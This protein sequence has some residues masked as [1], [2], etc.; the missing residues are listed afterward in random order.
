MSNFLKNDSGGIMIYSA[1]FL[2]IGVGAGALAID[3]GRMELL[4]SEMQHSADAAALSGA[5]QLNGHDDAMT[6]G[7]NVARNAMSQTSNVP[8]TGGNTPLTVATVNFYSSYAT[9]TIATTGLEAKFVEV[10]LAPQ[11]VNYMFAPVYSAMFGAARSATL[12]A[13]AV[14]RVRPFVCHAPPLMMCDLTELDPA[15]D[16]TDPANI[17]RQVRLKEPQGGSG[18][19][20]PGNFGLLALP[21]GSSGAPDIEGALAAIEPSECYEIDVITATGSKTNKVKD[22]INTRFDVGNMPDP[23]APNVI[24]YPQ[25][26]NLIPDFG[27]NIGDGIWDIDGYWAAKHNGDPAPVELAG[28]SRYQVYLY[29]L[30]ETFA[31]NGKMTSYPPPGGAAPA[32]YTLVVPPGPDLAVDAANPTLPDFDGVPQDPPASNGPARRLVEVALLQCIADGINGHGTYP[33]NGK[34]VEMFIT[35]EVK[36][37]PDAAIYGEIVRSLSSFNDPEFHANA[38]LIK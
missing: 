20:V 15:L 22:G 8:S 19:W 13:K 23:P 29:E 14:A 1:M 7:E 30:G 27:L 28:A 24:N 2:A 21:D 25:D 17:G 32:D 11:S 3:F 38:A 4:R 36:D 6:R 26:D 18:S 5:V 10:T 12:N 37:P 16:P 31:R 34:Y 33:T 9:K 35:Q